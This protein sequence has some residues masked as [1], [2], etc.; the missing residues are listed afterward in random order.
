MDHE[1]TYN[2]FKN[3]KKASDKIFKNIFIIKIQRQNKTVFKVNKGFFQKLR[4]NIQLSKKIW[5]SL[6][7]DERPDG[8]AP[9]YNHHS[10]HFQKSW[11]IQ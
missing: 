7:Y 4:S 6:F 8:D 3:W 5:M 1:R 9:C 11:A 2:Y 10:R